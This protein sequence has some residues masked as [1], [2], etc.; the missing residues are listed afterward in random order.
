MGSLELGQL[1]FDADTRGDD[2]GTD[3]IFNAAVGGVDVIGQ[4]QVGCISLDHLLANT[5]Q[6]Q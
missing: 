2:K 5:V 1:V 3:I 4:A 6:A